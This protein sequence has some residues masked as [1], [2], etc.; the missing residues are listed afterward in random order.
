L[1]CRGREL[2]AERHARQA[3]ADVADELR[4]RGVQRE[5][6]PSRPHALG[7]QLDRVRRRYVDGVSVDVG[8]GERSQRIDVLVVHLQRYT[9]R[10]QY[11]DVRQ[12]RQRGGENA[13]LR[14]DVLAV[15]E[16]DEQ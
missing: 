5:R 9:T 11:V 4:R 14:G 3:P 13:S 8:L 15:V 12:G 2:D 10:G 7:E 6:R 16:H 1:E